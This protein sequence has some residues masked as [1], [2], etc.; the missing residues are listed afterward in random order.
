MT[1]EEAFDAIAAI[2]DTWA[3]NSN[4]TSDQTRLF[5]L[6]EIAIEELDKIL[7]MGGAHPQPPPPR[8]RP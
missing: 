6:G 4:G 5:E 7:S 8:I 1:K 2:R 3:A